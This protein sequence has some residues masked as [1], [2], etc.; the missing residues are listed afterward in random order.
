MRNFSASKRIVIKI[1]TSTLS[2]NGGINSA[3]IQILAEQ[4]AWLAGTGRQVLMVSTAKNRRACYG[5]ETASGLCGD[6]TAP[7]DACLS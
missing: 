2:T 1:G 6:R 4:V 7:A 5:H 3:Y